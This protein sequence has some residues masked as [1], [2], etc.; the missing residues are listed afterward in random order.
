[1]SPE[2]ISLKFLM[3]K[4]LEKGFLLVLMGCD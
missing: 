1:V 4:V 2:N 3:I